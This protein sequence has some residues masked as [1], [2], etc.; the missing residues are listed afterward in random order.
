[1]QAYNF[2]AFIKP[3]LPVGSVL[4]PDYWRLLSLFGLSCNVRTKQ[5]TLGETWRNPETP[6]LTRSRQRK[7]TKRNLRRVDVRSI[8]LAFHQIST[9]IIFHWVPFDLTNDNLA[10]AQKKNCRIVLLKILP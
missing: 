10:T 1:M 2:H 7:L 9:C 8:K 3:E 5:R 6:L 4:D